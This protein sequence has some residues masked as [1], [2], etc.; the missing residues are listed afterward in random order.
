MNKK[1]LF[2]IIVLL[3]VIVVGVL[4]KHQQKSLVTVT[5]VNLNG[6]LVK[7]L[8]TKSF[9]SYCAQEDDYFT[10]KTGSEELVLE[11]E[12][13]YSEAQ[14]SNFSGKSVSV[15]GERKKREIECPE[16][17]QQCSPTSDG[18]FTCEVFKVS[19]ISESQSNNSVDC[20]DCGEGGWQKMREKCEQ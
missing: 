16:E 6:V 14:M 1:S 2:G 13:A 15:I 10:L 17:G 12:P 20:Y 9:E 18:I 8:G 5:G 19:K 11:F 3:V 4:Y 7:K